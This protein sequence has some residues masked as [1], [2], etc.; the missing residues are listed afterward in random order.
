MQP[1]NRELAV[2]DLLT[3]T[4]ESLGSEAQYLKVMALGRSAR[5]ADLIMRAAEKITKL[6]DSL[7]RSDRR[8]IKSLGC[9]RPVTVSAARW[10][11]VCTRKLTAK[12][13]N[14]K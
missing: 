7:G 9:T 5:E 12:N 2:P 1:R 11:F 14:F 10:S 3:I 6:G 8:E 13:S 4:I